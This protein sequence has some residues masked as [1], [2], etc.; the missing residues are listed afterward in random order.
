M[1]LTSSLPLR[2]HRSEPPSPDGRNGASPG[3]RAAGALPTGASAAPRTVVRGV[4]AAQSL[5]ADH[6]RRTERPL[7]S[8]MAISSDRPPV[9]RL[10]P[11]MNRTPTGGVPTVRT[12]GSGRANSAGTAPCPTAGCE[13]GTVPVATRRDESPSRTWSV[14]AR[15]TNATTSASSGRRRV[16][17]AGGGRLRVSC[18]GAG[19]R[20][21]RWESSPM[22][23][24]IS[25]SRGSVTGVAPPI[26]VVRLRAPVRRSVRTR[27]GRERSLLPPPPP[28]RSDRPRRAGEP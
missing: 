2:H 23:R 8:A 19:G 6:S 24:R 12:V 25:V 17:G 14:T 13:V 21:A 10:A 28:S 16:C 1:R 20:G 9:A 11:S 27:R 3:L 5:G 15:P 22:K 7:A 18:S 4:P 26:V